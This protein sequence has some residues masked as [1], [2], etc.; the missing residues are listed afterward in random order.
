MF[1]VPSALASAL[2]SA[3]VI[4]DAER[5]EPVRTGKSTAIPDLIVL[6]KTPG[7]KTGVI[8]GLIAAFTQWS[9]VKDPNTAPTFG[10]YDAENNS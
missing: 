9:K 3:P 2:V 8:N 1:A 5:K 6:Y 10:K 7:A 4:A